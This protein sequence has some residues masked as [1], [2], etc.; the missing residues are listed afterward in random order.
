MPNNE[1]ASPCHSSRGRIPEVDN[2]DSLISLFASSFQSSSS[3]AAPRTSASFLPVSSPIPP[4]HSYQSDLDVL[5]MAGDLTGEDPYEMDDLFQLNH[6]E[7][8]P[9]HG[10][11]Q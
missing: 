2:E 8:L 11:K 7:A 9:S 1:V 3:P 6:H 5:T 4:S 10:P